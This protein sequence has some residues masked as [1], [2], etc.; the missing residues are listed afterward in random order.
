MVRLSK[1]WLATE[2]LTRPGLTAA[3]DGRDDGAGGILTDHATFQSAIFSTPRRA[4]EP[5]LG[6]FVEKMA[7]PI[8]KLLKLDCLD[9]NGNLKPDSLCAKRRDWMNGLGKKGN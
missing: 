1:E 5:G 9:G 4:Q 2:E 3:I 6:D 7:K 8:A